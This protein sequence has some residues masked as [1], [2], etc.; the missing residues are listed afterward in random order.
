MWDQ[1]DKI[2]KL[3]SPI[4]TNS[5]SGTV[6]VCFSQGGLICRGLLATIPHNVETFISLS[7]PL[8]GQFG[9]TDYLKFF[10][11][12]YVK[13]NI[14]KLFYTEVGQVFSVGGY[15]KD[16]HEQKL[17][18]KFSTYLATLNNQSDTFNPKSH[19]FKENF[20]R[21]KNIVMVGGPDDGVITPWQ[22][23]QFGMYNASEKVLPMEKQEWYLNDAFGLQTLAKRG[24]LH[25]H[26]IPGIHHVRW[27]KELQIFKC[28]VLPWLT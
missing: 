15:W 3:V 14:Y 26:T 21:L 17:F 10:F 24:G 13:E 18:Q 28:C 25:L 27:H 19:E 11:P 4:L 1:V 6:L 16:P 7:S 23:S 20:L 9:D 12:Y 2:S 5:S 8:A 22:S